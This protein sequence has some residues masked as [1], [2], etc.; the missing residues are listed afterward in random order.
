MPQK[1]PD[2]KS[3][4]ISAVNISSKQVGGDY[5]DIIELDK[6]DC[7]VAIADVSGKGVP[8]SLLMANMQA[9]LQVICRQNTPLDEATGL[10]NDLI[11]SN[12]SDGRFIT[13]FWGILNDITKT[14]NYVNAGHNPPLLIRNG[15]ITK[16]E[17]GGMILGVMKTMIP[18]KSES[19]QLQTGDVLV[20][21]TDGISEAMNRRGE[22]FSD[23]R[24][25]KLS[26]AVVNENADSI[27]KKIQCEVQNFTDGANQSDDITLVIVKVK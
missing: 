22:E 10:I 2:Y 19:I 20:M 9:F 14:F 24:L 8:A 18:Y 17:I 23:E 21:F 1:I 6:D 11:S 4:D 15:T 27:L 5:Y 7:V 26:L 16:L 25:E 13:F 3:F 12:T